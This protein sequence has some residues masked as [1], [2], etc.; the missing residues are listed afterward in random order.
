[1]LEQKIKIT[2]RGTLGF[3]FCD[4]I[5]YVDTSDARYET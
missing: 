2:I 5:K 4:T 1:M 3:K